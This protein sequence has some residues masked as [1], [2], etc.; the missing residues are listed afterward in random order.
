MVHKSEALGFGAM[1]A[2]DLCV[3]AMECYDG[4]IGRMQHAKVGVTWIWGFWVWAKFR[5]TA[6]GPKTLHGGLH[7]TLRNTQSTPKEMVIL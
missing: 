6:W 2:L 5:S 1:F 3:G 4:Y 7:C